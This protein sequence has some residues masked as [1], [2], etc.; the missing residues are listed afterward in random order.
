VV[1]RFITISSN[2][3][4]RLFGAKPKT[5]FRR[6]AEEEAVSGFLCLSRSRGTEKGVALNVDTLETVNGSNGVEVDG[7]CDDD[8]EETWRHMREFVDEIDQ[9][10]SL[11]EIPEDDWEIYVEYCAALGQPVSERDLLRKENRSCIQRK[12]TSCSRRRMTAR[13]RSDLNN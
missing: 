2:V 12:S 4:G 10:Y 3:A 13:S 7:C 9:N 5:S 6:R 11:E 8:L 1:C